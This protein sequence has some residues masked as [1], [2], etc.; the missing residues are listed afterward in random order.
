MGVVLLTV[1]LFEFCFLPVVFSTIRLL[2]HFDI[3]LLLCSTLDLWPLKGCPP[4][5]YRYRHNIIIQPLRNL[6]HPGMY[7]THPCKGY[8]ATEVHNNL[9]LASST[10]LSICCSGNDNSS[11]WSQILVVLWKQCQPTLHLWLFCLLDFFKTTKCLGCHELQ[12]A[13]A[14]IIF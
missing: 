3:I 9:C 7:C 6:V 1:C 14:Y 8:N 11:K 5:L 13:N 10:V 4:L 12:W 2:N